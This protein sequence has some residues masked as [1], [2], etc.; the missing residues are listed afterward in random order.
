[1]PAQHSCMLIAVMQT[2]GARGEAGGSA[3][4]AYEGLTLRDSGERELTVVNQADVP[5]G[6]S[7]GDEH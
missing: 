6:D 1:M 5:V 2:C 3:K 7:Q 4:N